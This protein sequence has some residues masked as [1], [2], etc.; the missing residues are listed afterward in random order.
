MGYRLK[1]VIEATRCREVPIRAAIMPTD[2]L[3]R[4]LIVI[5]GPEFNLISRVIEMKLPEDQRVHSAN[6]GP[7]MG[8]INVVESPFGVMSAESRSSPQSEAIGYYFGGCPAALYIAGSDDDGLLAAAY[9]LIL[10]IWGR[11]GKYR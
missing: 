9:E 1:I 4:P 7:G 10:R 11:E 6:P 3:N 8:L 5:G 2:I